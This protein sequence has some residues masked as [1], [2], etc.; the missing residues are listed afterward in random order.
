MIILNPCFEDFEVL[1]KTKS[2]VSV[3]VTDNTVCTGLVTSAKNPTHIRIGSYTGSIS[4]IKLVTVDEPT[5][6]KA[7]RL[8]DDGFPGYTEQVTERL[9]GREDVLIER[10]G[11]VGEPV[12]T[13]TLLSYSAEKAYYAAVKEVSTKLPPPAPAEPEAAPGRIY[14]P[15]LEQIE[16][17]AGVCV[18]ACVGQSFGGATHLRRVYLVVQR[19]H[20]SPYTGLSLFLKVYDPDSGSELDSFNLYTHPVDWIEQCNDHANQNEAATEQPR[21]AT[22]ILFHASDTPDDLA[23]KNDS[24]GEELV[25]DKAVKV[26]NIVYETDFTVDQGLFFMGILE[27]VRSFSK[28]GTAPTQNIK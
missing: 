2:V 14:K 23:V 7:Y 26:F 3:V 28:P 20:T 9:R 1:E 21:K 10:T 19:D 18:N 12:T 5:Y 22:E 24:D 4:S 17:F 15:D 25:V 13:V 6:R 27:R 16:Q 11:R 8:S